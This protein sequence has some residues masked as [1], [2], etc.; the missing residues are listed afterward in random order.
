MTK[1]M[2]PLKIGLIAEVDDQI[3]N[4]CSNNFNRD[5]LTNS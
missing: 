1:L 3:T 4:L 5:I 2:L